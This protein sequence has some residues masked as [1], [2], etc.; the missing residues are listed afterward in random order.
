MLCITDSSE[1]VK[2]FDK[3]FK[4]AYKFKTLPQRS[5]KAISSSSSLCGLAIDGDEYLIVGEQNDYI[6]IHKICG[7]HI[8][9]FSLD[10]TPYF[11]SVSPSKKVIVVTN[12]GS[13]T[14]KIVNYK[15][16]ILHTL[17]SP[18]PTLAG[19]CFDGANEFLVVRQRGPDNGVHRYSIDG[20][21]LGRI[22]SVVDNPTGVLITEDGKILV[23]EL[24]HIKVFTKM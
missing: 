4:L 12:C 8:F 7:E 9:S 10:V 18:I 3:D 23:L 20:I 1:F 2:V 15:G 11:I 21:Y 24:T 22:T 19:A 14:T 6:S 13:N 5:H 17:D 16:Q